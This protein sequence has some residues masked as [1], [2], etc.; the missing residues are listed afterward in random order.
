MTTIPDKK[1]WKN[2]AGYL[3]MD[4]VKIYRW[5]QPGGTVAVGIFSKSIVIDEYIRLTDYC[6][7]FQ[8]EVVAIQAAVK[9]RIS[10]METSL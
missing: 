3:I 2:G 9:I 7:V 10:A 5:I 1:I 8:A 4:S 6:S